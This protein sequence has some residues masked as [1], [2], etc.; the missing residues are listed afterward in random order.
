MF[1][2]I[3][4]R[5]I[6]LISKTP[7]WAL[8]RLSDFLFFI[9]QHLLHY[10]KK[11]I[12]DNLKKCFPDFS[13]QE[14]KKTYRQFNRNLCDYAVESVKALTISQKELDKRIE[15]KNIEVFHEIKAEG[16]NCMMLCGHL[17]NWEWLIGMANHVPQNHALTVYHKLKNESVDSFMK[18]SRERFGT[19]AITMQETARTIIDTPNNGD[20]TFLFVSDQSPAQV[21]IR[22][23]L[24]FFN[25]LTPVFNGFDKLARRMNYGIVYIDI[26]KT[27][28]GHYC[29][30]FKRLKPS[31]EQFKE[32]EIVDLFYKSLEENIKRDPANWLWSHRR[33]KYKKG[34]HY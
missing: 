15:L 24:Q 2:N 16:K 26:S 18:Q 3:A 14:I 10:R 31:G 29:F 20:Y 32:N 23:D 4:K 19:K 28:R 34:I 8:Y 17:F 13:D 30:E 1:L 5:L 21:L 11:V 27:K 6:Y 12:I 22:Y 25:Q 9:Q 33:W 7:L